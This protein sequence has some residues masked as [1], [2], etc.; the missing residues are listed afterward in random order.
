MSANNGKPI[1][2]TG[3]HRSGTT[4]TARMLAAAPELGYIWEPFNPLQRP[5]ICAAPFGHWFTYVTRSNEAQYLDPL[6][7]TLA[8]TV[9]TCAS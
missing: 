8:V 6:R 4:W 1:L 5:G 2:V 3:T 9:G 7:R